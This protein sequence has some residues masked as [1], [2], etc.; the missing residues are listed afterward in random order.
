MEVQQRWHQVMGREG[1]TVLDLIDGYRR[2]VSV[3][4][5]CTVMFCFGSFLAVTHFFPSNTET[6]LFKQRSD[7]DIHLKSTG[8]PRV[9]NLTES[10][11]HRRVSQ[12]G[13]HQLG[14]HLDSPEARV[15]TKVQSNNHDG[16]LLLKESF[17]PQIFEDHVS[18]LLGTSV[19]NITCEAL[20]RYRPLVESPYPAH[21]IHIP[22]CS[23]ASLAA[24]IRELKSGTRFSKKHGGVRGCVTFKLKNSPVEDWHHQQ[25]PNEQVENDL[26]QCDFISTHT[27]YGFP[28]TWGAAVNTHI[29]ILREPFSHLVSKYDYIRHY[30]ALDEKHNYLKITPMSKFISDSMQ[31]PLQK[32]ETWWNDP[33]ELPNGIAIGN[34]QT[35]FMCGAACSVKH[36]SMEQALNQA[37]ENLITKI[38]FVGVVEDEASL[39]KRLNPMYGF[40]PLE[41]RHS[42]KYKG[43]HTVLTELDRMRLAQ[44]LHADITLHQIAGF[45]SRCSSL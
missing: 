14:H 44:L 22:K 4:T 26:E 34:Q 12:P 13:A 38:H 20:P 27:P 5:I 23:G 43:E 11:R 9:Q 2:A 39:Y 29:T 37:V 6:L 15:L 40:L 18:V 10:I 36:M 32:R 33:L 28:E 16:K 8:R 31:L 7:I 1:P 21:H 19:V 35:W 3:T 17:V 30:K 41:A 45:V 25:P 24:I 42:N